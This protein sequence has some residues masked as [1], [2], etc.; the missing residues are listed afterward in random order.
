[1]I[2]NFTINQP[3]FHIPGIPVERR[4]IY[5]QGLRNGFHLGVAHSNIDFE[6]V[7]F[8]KYL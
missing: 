2:S 4:Y 1:M 6:K 5:S 3:D 7:D 8:Q